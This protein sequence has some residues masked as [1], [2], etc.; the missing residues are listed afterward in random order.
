ML[1]KKFPDVKGYD[2]YG[3]SIPAKEVGGDYYDF[4]K[5]ENSKLAF[6]LGDVSGKGISAA[7]LMANLQATFRSHIYTCDSPKACMCWS[8]RLLYQSTDS[9]KYAT[10]FCGILDFQLHEINFSN[11]GHNNPIFIT[12]NNRNLDQFHITRQYNEVNVMLL[13]CR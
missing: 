3:I 8:N 2:I 13:Q 9:E 11:A 5:L 10:F 12:P 4:I 7:M 1:P 6:C